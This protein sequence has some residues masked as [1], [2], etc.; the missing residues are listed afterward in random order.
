MAWNFFGKKEEPKIELPK[1]SERMIDG[2][3]L[4]KSDFG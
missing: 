3:L 4:N 2:A 1:Q